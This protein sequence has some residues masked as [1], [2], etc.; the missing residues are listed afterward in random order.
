MHILLGIVLPLLVQ[1]LGFGLVILVSQGG[2]SFVGLLALSAGVL[3]VPMVTLLN[4]ARTRHDPP[5]PLLRLAA[6]AMLLALVVPVFLLLLRVV[7]P[8]L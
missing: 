6:V 3:A 4:W 2:G 5:I 7:E 1:L 8:H